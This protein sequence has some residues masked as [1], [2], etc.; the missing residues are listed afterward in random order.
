MCLAIQHGI[1]YLQIRCLYFLL[2]SSSK[3]FFKK[4]SFVTDQISIEIAIPELTKLPNPRMGTPPSIA[5]YNPEIPPH[6]LVITFLGIGSSSSSY[7][8]NTL[9]GI[10]ARDSI[11]A[12]FICSVFTFGNFLG[13]FKCIPPISTT[14]D[15]IGLAGSIVK[16]LFTNIK[17]GGIG[18]CKSYSCGSV[19]RS[20]NSLNLSMAVQ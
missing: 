19:N 16:C 5:S 4:F 15:W 10:C 2:L 3:T 9:C 18:A 14:F 17:D 11:N 7:F 13:A 6:F 8:I 20:Q 12:F 1:K